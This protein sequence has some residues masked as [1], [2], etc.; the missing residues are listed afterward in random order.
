MRWQRYQETLGWTELTPPPFQP[1]S[2]TSVNPDIFLVR[3]STFIITYSLKNETWT[4]TT[5][6]AISLIH[7]H[8][9]LCEMHKGD[10]VACSQC[11]DFTVAISYYKPHLFSICVRILVVHTVGVCS[12]LWNVCPLSGVNPKSSSSA[13]GRGACGNLWA[14]SRLT[15]GPGLEFPLKKGKKDKHH[16]NHIKHQTM[17]QLWIINRIKFNCL[18]KLWFCMT[19]I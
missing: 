6:T 10:V 14:S 13:G 5:L 17:N 18:F 7:N 16:M 8:Q 2:T 12:E 11:V 1:N 19:E 9:K 3:Q 15:R 4:I